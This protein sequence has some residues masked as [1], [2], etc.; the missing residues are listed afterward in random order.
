MEETHPTPQHGKRMTTE[1]QSIGS[2]MPN[3]QARVREILGL[4]KEI[5]PSGAFGAM[6]IE[7]DLREAD[8]AVMSGDIVRIIRAYQTLKEIE[9]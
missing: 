4:Y 7:A 1:A 8:E 6:T 9:A 2:D 3:Q 5:G